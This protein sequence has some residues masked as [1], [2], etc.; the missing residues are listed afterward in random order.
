MHVLDLHSTKALIGPNQGL[1]LSPTKAL[2]GPQPRPWSALNQGI[3]RRSIK[4][5][6]QPVGLCSMLYLWWS[7]AISRALLMVMNTV[8]VVFS[9]AD[10][11]G[12]DLWLSYGA[13]HVQ[14]GAFAICTQFRRGGSFVSVEF[15]GGWESLHP[16]G[17]SHV[18]TAGNLGGS[19]LL[20]ATSVTV[21]TDNLSGSQLLL[22]LSVAV[23]SAIDRDHV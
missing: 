11:P 5:L 17:G 14:V 3:D 16:L 23:S 6:S 21:T 19:Q 10:Y 1:G 12:R 15:K 9:C 8:N 2:I 18:V 20:L 4:A 22:A 7:P 13:N